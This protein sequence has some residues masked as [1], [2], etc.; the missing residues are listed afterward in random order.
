MAQWMHQFSGS[1]HATKV[2]G[3][4]NAL[5]VAVAAQYGAQSAAERDKKKAAVSKLATRLLAARLRLYRSRLS[6]MEPRG[7]AHGG[8]TAREA[9]AR[10]GGVAAILK[11]F[12]AQS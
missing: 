7:H 4:E 6:D 9:E 2:A 12:G 3:L 11:E 5:R 8:L 1:S 10:A